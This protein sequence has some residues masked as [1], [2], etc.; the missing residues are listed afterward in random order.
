MPDE[1]GL[2][3][4]LRHPDASSAR[5]PPSRVVIGAPNEAGTRA[6]FTLETPAANSFVYE[7]DDL[8]RRDEPRP[9][10]SS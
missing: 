3:A 9:I 7:G 5:S 1:T 8:R 10:G 2:V 6:T 4:A